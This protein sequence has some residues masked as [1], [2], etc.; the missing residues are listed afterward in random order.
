VIIAA[1]QDNGVGS[2][3]LFSIPSASIPPSLTI[4]RTTTN[5]VVVSWSAAATGFILQQNT[6]GFGSVN[7]SNV[8]TGIQDDG[9]KKTL[10]VN[11]SG[12]SRFYRLALP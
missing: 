7:W 4:Q 9:P 3:Y 5:A 12:P 2:A 1:P 10:V 8:A 11:P 6:N